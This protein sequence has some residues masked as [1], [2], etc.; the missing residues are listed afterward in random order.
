VETV[1]PQEQLQF[2]ASCFVRSCRVV[3]GLWLAGPGRPALFLALSGSKGTPLFV[4]KKKRKKEKEKVLYAYIFVGC[5][6]FP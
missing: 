6:I 5:R 3:S 1:W 2:L 4:S